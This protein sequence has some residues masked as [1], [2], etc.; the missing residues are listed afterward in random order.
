VIFVPFVV[1]SSSTINGE[2]GK[3]MALT[4]ALLGWL[5]D[6]FE[7]GMFPLVGQKALVELLPSQSAAERTVWFGV[8]MA[9]F[10]IGA[11]TGGVVF[12]W[13]GD[14]V[15][16][17]RAMALSIF[18]YAI[19]TGLC[20]FATHAWHIAVL[21]F[22]ASLGMGGEWALGVA[23]VTEMWP[24]RSRALLAG[25]I[26]AAANVGYLVV[27]LIS[28]GLVSFI[29][30]FGRLLLNVGAS[31]ELVETLVSGDGWRLMMIVGAVPSILVFF[32][33]LFVPESHKWEA[34]R[35]RGATSHWATRDLLGVLIGAIGAGA[36]VVMW[37][38]GFR[39]L[40]NLIVSDEGELGGFGSVVNIVRGVLSVLGIAAALL[41]FMYPVVRYLGRAEEAGALDEGDRG[42]CVRRLLFGA[43]LAGVALLG[44][45]GSLQWA[46][47]WSIALS[48]NTLK[49]KEYT[50]ISM[51][52]GAILG[53]LA[54][55]L[56][57]GW[58]GR[59]ITYALL[60]V[61]SFVSLIYLY[62]GND[63]YGPK[64]LISAF[65]AGGITAAFYGWFP[66]YLPELFP[67]SIRATSQ[68]FAF[69][70]GRVIS[71]VGTL[72][73]A[74]ITSYFAVGVAPERVE[75]DAV[76]KAAATLAAIYLVGVVIIWFGPETKGKPLPEHLRDI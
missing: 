5:F 53:T 60:C 61:A 22:I 76:A 26:G 56:M 69:N 18:T 25:L 9:V 41:G 43:C 48:E 12:G 2:R 63:V 50:Q 14:R 58:I 30:G 21:R 20:G 4:A 28:L 38:P 16:R 52:A 27:G 13:L 65:V 34:E 68:G 7:M 73:T 75:I 49:A 64:F 35:D 19:F 6:G 39:Y 8:I 17:V 40:A 10:L 67:T 45:W 24:D 31:Q 62:Q 42:R 46:P 72:Q 66:L 47:K 32:I 74:A 23:L 44:T 51:A 55:A 3:W 37:S 15:G 1:N 54:A 59:R 70:F 11:A 71:A 57:G 29:E 36:V 33:R